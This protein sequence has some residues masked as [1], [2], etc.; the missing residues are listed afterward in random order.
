MLHTESARQA[1]AFKLTEFNSI[2][3]QTMQQALG[4]SSDVLCEIFR[5]E[6]NLAVWQR[7]TNPELLRYTSQLPEDLLIK[8][9]LP[10]DEIPSTLQ[11]LLPDGEGRD[12]LAADIYD[13]AQ[14]LGCVMDTDTIGVRLAVLQQAQC[15]NWHTDAVMLRLLITYQGEGTQYLQGGLGSNACQVLPQQIALLKGSAWSDKSMAIVHR[16][17]PG[18]ARRVVLTLDPL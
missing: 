2:A 17:P 5:D 13:A 18:L 11:R 10:L 16:S 4:E 6:V 8:R 9:M 7:P 14:M 3:T 15:P 12:A 1:T